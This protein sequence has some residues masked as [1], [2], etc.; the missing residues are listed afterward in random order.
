[1]QPQPITMPGAQVQETDKHTD[2]ELDEMRM[3]E[4]KD[5]ELN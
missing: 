1:M 2:C 3:M 5:I 4:E